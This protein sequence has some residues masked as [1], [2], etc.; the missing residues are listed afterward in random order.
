MKPKSSKIHFAKENS[1]CCNETKLSSL[2]F[3]LYCFDLT[4][5]IAICL[6]N[7]NIATNGIPPW[8]CIGGDENS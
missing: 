8:L 5:L 6:S 3:V 2:V 7:A 4:H 1:Y